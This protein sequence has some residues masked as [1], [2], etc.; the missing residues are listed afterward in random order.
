MRQSPFMTVQTDW[1]LSM[2]ARSLPELTGRLDLTS[3]KMASTDLCDPMRGCDMCD[4][5]QC[6]TVL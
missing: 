3:S 5:H 2:K 4:R 1:K 6:A